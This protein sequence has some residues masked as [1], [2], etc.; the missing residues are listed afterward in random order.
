MQDLK[1]AIERL[2]CVP[3]MAPLLKLLTV[4]TGQRKMTSACLSPCRKKVACAFIDSSLAVWNLQVA[5]R[6][7][8]HQPCS[9]FSKNRV[10]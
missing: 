4:D 2:R 6:V 3:T 5:I 10:Q 9:F 8:L 1:A 7:W